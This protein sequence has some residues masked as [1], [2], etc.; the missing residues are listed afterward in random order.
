MK[1]FVP[2]PL[3]RK[4]SLETVYLSQ[5]LE[6]GRRRGPQCPKKKPIALVNCPPLVTFCFTRESLM[7]T[8]RAHK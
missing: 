7:L 1:S 4:E 5:G 6:G 3:S 8:E 2:F